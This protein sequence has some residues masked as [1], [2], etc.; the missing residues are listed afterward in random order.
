MTSDSIKSEDIKAQLRSNDDKMASVM[1]SIFWLQCRTM[2]GSD[3][4]V[5]VN[6]TDIYCFVQVLLMVCTPVVT[7][8]VFL[9]LQIVHLHTTSFMA[10]VEVKKRSHSEQFQLSILS[11]Q[12]R[13]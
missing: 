10:T 3:D 4:T 13:Q 12:I 1:S 8:H 9:I 5:S 2:G 11:Q 7:K 6:M